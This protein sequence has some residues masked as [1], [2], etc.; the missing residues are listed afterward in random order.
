MLNRVEVIKAKLSGNWDNSS[1]CSSRSVNVNNASG[2]VNSNNGER[3]CSDTKVSYIRYVAYSSAESLSL[4]KAKTQNRSVRG[5]VAKAKVSLPKY[6]ISLSALILKS[7]D[8][9]N[10]I[11]GGE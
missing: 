1:S 5:L 4:V 6:L 8:L 3:S 11:L 7:A 2:D 10:L 9:L